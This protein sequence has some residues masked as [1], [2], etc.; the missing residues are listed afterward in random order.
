MSREHGSLRDLD[1][2]HSWREVYAALDAPVEQHNTEV[3]AND[4]G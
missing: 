2:H 4:A 3:P 1:Q